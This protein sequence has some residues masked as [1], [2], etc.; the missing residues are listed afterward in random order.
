MCICAGCRLCRHPTGGGRSSWHQSS[1]AAWKSYFDKIIQV[2]FNMPTTAYRMDEYILGLLGWDL[3]GKKSLRVMA[4]IIFRRLTSEAKE[5]VEY[6]HNIT[7]VSVGQNPRSIKRVA[8]FV[9]LLRMVGN[10]RLGTTKKWE[11]SFKQWDIHTARYSTRL[12][13]SKL[14][15][16]NCLNT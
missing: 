10:A 1:T 8:A 6:F 14:S 3:V 15:G 7:K 16:Q 5:H 4:R 13:V 12:L 11:G 9:R 2:P